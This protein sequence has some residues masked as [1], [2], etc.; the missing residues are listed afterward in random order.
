MYDPADV[1]LPRRREGELADMPEWAKDFMPVDR[2]ET[3]GAP[4]APDAKGYVLPDEF[5]REIRAL[6]YGM[7]SLID[8]HCGRVIDALRASRELENTI[9]GF[10]CDHVEILYDID[11]E[12][13][14]IA[15]EYGLQLERIESM[16]TDARFIQAIADAILEK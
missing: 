13:K 2:L 7:I 5:M 12:A 11:I 3:T 9:I 8:K 16:N 6:T 1:P 14:Q 10:V 4:H 15:D